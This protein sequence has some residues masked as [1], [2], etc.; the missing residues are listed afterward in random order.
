MRFVPR[1]GPEEIALFGLDADGVAQAHELLD[2]LGRDA[3]GAVARQALDL[4]S[5]ACAGAIHA[6]LNSPYPWPWLASELDASMAREAENFDGRKLFCAIIA[7]AGSAQDSL[8]PA[9]AREALARLGAFCSDEMTCPSEAQAMS[10]QAKRGLA[11][12]LEAGL[13]HPLPKRPL[14]TALGAWALPLLYTPSRHGPH[15]ELPPKEAGLLAASLAEA[16]DKAA[17]AEGAI[18][19]GLG[20]WSSILERAPSLCAPLRLRAKIEQLASSI[21]IAPAELAVS[22][23]FHEEDSS[24]WMRVALRPNATGFCLDGLDWPAGPD[25]LEA[26]FDSLLDAL[27]DCGVEWCYQ[28]EGTFGALVCETCGEPIY[29]APAQPEWTQAALDAG[30]PPDGSHAHD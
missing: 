28:V 9:G 12:A 26:A 16:L 23:S 14:P 4:S 18:L 10:H 19:L 3:I 2:A 15:D 7:R 29:P 13:P 8:A 11:E 6:A 21:M 22:V 27:Q 20:P 24:Q 17:R 25:G 1:L 5:A 30:A